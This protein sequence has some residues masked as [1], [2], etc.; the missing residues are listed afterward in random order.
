MTSNL[1]RSKNIVTSK[2]NLY[3]ISSLTL[4][5]Y[6]GTRLFQLD[7][8]PLF[9][10]ES[11]IIEWAIQVRE[12]SPIG[13]GYH[14]KYL[15]PWVYSLLFTET[16]AYWSV[17]FVTLLLLMIGASAI[18]RLGKKL[19][20]WLVG[21][22]TVIVMTFIPML[23]FHDRLALTDT[24]LHAMLSLHVLIIFY[25]L[26]RKQPNL[27]LTLFI[28]ATFIMALLAKSTAVVLIPLPFIGMVFL[29]NQWQ[30]RSRILH[31]VIMYGAMGLAWLPLHL[32]L[33]WRGMNYFGLAG[34]FSSEINNSS[35]LDKLSANSQV[36]L[37]GFIHYFG[38][39]GL[40]TMSLAMMM[41]LFKKPRHGFV[42]IAGIVG[43][44]FALILAAFPGGIANR[45]WIGV[46]PIILLVTV[47]GFSLLPYKQ[48]G[49]GAIVIYSLVLG[50]PF[51]WQAYTAPSDLD[52]SRNDRL[53]YIESDA[54]GTILPDIARYLDEQDNLVIVAIPQCF[55]VQLYTDSTIECFNVV[56]DNQR[57]QRLSNRLDE[58]TEPYL[59]L[60]ETP[61]YINKE[62][63]LGDNAD[64]IA[65]YERPGG[66]ITLELYLV[67]P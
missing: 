22:L 15:L 56:Q 1:K 67:T 66:L 11:I 13:F 49:L 14:G 64:L 38:W 5:S 2:L 41:L 43:F 18:I 45:Y 61:G 39:L 46:V 20:S 19:S 65:E 57:V 59:L 37:E 31:T 9:L 63:I 26:D 33:A 27:L 52:L 3:L 53:H 35:L 4:L 47:Y 7:A 55:T 58:L 50:L 6:L 17:R 42:L 34:Q 25:A 16:G 60:L 32:L 23:F 51:Q 36:I 44:V 54:A 29:S 40:V 10:D 62:D 24:I 28:S 8:L 21:I 48:V 12:G 30:W